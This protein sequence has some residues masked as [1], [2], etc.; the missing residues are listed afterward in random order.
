MKDTHTSGTRNGKA[1][2]SLL[3]LTLLAGLGF[4]IFG[5]WCLQYAT[6]SDYGIVGLMAKH[7]AEE[8][9]YPVFFYGQP[10]MGSFE[11]AISALLCRIMGISGFAVCLGTGLLA[12]VLLPILYLWAR[13]ARDRIAGLA[14]VV[15]SLV[16][17]FAYFFYCAAPRGGYVST[18]VFGAVTVWLA[19]RIAMRA[20]TGG[21]VQGSRCLLL[22]LA[23]G[24]A[25]WSNQ[26][27]VPFLAAAALT[28]LI[29]LRGRIFRL[30][31]LLGGGIG[32]TAGSLPWWIWNVTHHWESLQFGGTLGQTPFMEGV[33]IFGRIFAELLEVQQKPAWVLALLALAYGSLLVGYGLE[34]RA[35]WRERQA[36]FLPLL[37]PVFVVLFMAL[38]YST[39]HF[40]RMAEVR[41]ILPAFP[42]VAIMVGIGTARW[43]Q[44]TRLGWVPLLVLVVVQCCF[45]PNLAKYRTE[46]KKKWAAAAEI[47]GFLKAQSIDVAYGG[48]GD[49]WM[50]FATLEALCVTSLEGDRYAPYEKRAAAAA[51]V[52][53]F[54]DHLDVADFIAH[55]GGTAASTSVAGHKLFY[56]VQPPTLDVTALPTQNIATV[57]AGLGGHDVLARLHDLDLDTGYAVTLESNARASLEW[58]FV[59]AESICGLQVFH[60]EGDY[61]WQAQ[62]EGRESGSTTWKTLLPWTKSAFMFWSGPRPCY[63]GAGCYLE[64]RFPAGDYDAVRLSVASGGRRTRPVHLGE[65]VWLQPGPGAPP[66]DPAIG[67]VVGALQARHIERLYAPR[68]ISEQVC[69]RTGGAIETSASSFFARHLSDGPGNLDKVSKAIEVMTHKTALLVYQQDAARTR[70]C[71]ARVGLNAMETAVGPWTLFD[72]PQELTAQGH[73]FPPLR[74]TESG[75]FLSQQLAT[76]KNAEVWYQLAQK[77]LSSSAHSNEVVEALRRTLAFYPAYQPA[78]AQLADQLSRAGQTNEALICRQELRRQT[79]PSSDLDASFAGGVKLLGIDPPVQPVRR[80]SSFPLTYYW[81]CPPAAKADDWAVFVHFVRDGQTAF[82]DDRVLLADVPPAVLHDQPFPEIFRESRMVRIP[83]G[84]TPGEYRIQMGLYNRLTEKRERPRTSLPVDHKAMWLPVTLRVEE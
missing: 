53:Y 8:T 25:W 77:G 72:C 31:L 55:S 58:T 45:L 35:R 7:M 63:Q 57:T 84:V 74:W 6:N 40:A 48:Y 82:Q 46:Q 1:W 29:G 60:P 2:A 5:A 49:H 47:A 27:V 79:D 76:K 70:D 83:E 17:S 66:P 23:A 32:F 62:V 30:A 42:A 10:Y 56:D 19:A 67:E 59:R 61:L 14:A 34:L 20:W 9:D 24:V 11:P 21:P 64:Y 13:D 78:L 37:S 22:G 51:R 41:Y 3:M 69:Q 16:G 81:Q 68:W 73:A 28:L 80:G 33:G 54:S 39:S 12:F 71:L 4:R 43:A 18:L 36:A 26:L 52:A 44:R 15:F 75:C 38:V 65:V 50:N